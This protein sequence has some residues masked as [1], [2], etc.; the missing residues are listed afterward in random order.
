MYVR[1]FN[2]AGI[3]AFRQLLADCRKR[4]MLPT[5][6]EMLPMRL[7]LLE[8]ESLSTLISPKCVAEDNPFATKGEAAEHFHNMLKEI[9][10]SQLIA[11]AGLWS[12]LGLRYFDQVCADSGEGNSIKSDYFYIYEPKSNW[13]FHKHLLY[14][15]WRILRVAPQHNRLMLSTPVN[16]LDNIT[17]TIM[18][19][20]YLT[21]IPCIFEVLDRLY[22]DSTNNRAKKGITLNKPKRGDLNHRFPIRLRQLEKTYDLQSVS[23]N[24]LIELL[25]AEFSIVPVQK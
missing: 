18:P 23:A 8:D 25:G 24:Q 15:S 10:E 4:P 17:D 20:L 1:E 2:D 22:W 21:R 14:I 3:K 9:P 7:K 11:N 19:K 12:W 16:S 6:L 13:N 5:R